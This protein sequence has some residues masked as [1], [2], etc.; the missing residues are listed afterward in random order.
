MDFL[1][2]IYPRPQDAPWIG[3]R[4]QRLDLL[5][6][7]VGLNNLPL[8]AYHGDGPN[9][10]SWGGSVLQAP[11]DGKYYMWAASMVQNC[12]MGEWTTNSEVD[13][14][15]AMILCMHA[16]HLCLAL[17]SSLANAFSLGAPAVE[18]QLLHPHPRAAACVH[19]HCSR[20][21]QCERTPR[22]GAG[23]SAVLYVPQSS[24]LTPPQ[25]RLLALACIL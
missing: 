14:M 10:T 6:G 9:S 23:R 21:S 7:T 13:R 18:A 25:L 11:E 22:F 4:C 16:W 2:L 12:T 19:Y 17:A 20:H 24:S 3:E 15:R 8:C 5:P 1:L